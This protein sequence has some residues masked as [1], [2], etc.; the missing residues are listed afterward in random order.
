MS[1]KVIRIVNI[2]VLLS[3]CVILLS[4][5]SKVNR[6][7]DKSLGSNDTGKL[8]IVTTIFPYYDFVRQIAGDKVELRLVVPAGMDTHSFEPTAEDMIAISEADIFIYN[9]G[10]MESWVE[11]VLS[12]TDTGNQR[13]E[14]MIEQVDTLEEEFVEGMSG[15]EGN[16]G[17]SHN[18]H[19]HTEHE[20]SADGEAEIDEHIWTSPENAKILVS[21][22]L[23]ILIG[24]D[25][26]N[27][28]FYSKNADIYIKK[29][30]ELDNKIS[31]IV[32]KGKRK[33]LVFAD[34]FP[35]RYF[36]EEYGIGY[37]AAFAG[38]SADIEPSADTIAYLTDK[39][40]NEKIPVVLKIELTSSRV[41]NV[42][43]DMTGAEVELFYTC[44]NVTRKQFEHGISYVELM[45]HNIRVLKKALY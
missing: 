33:N 11:R 9:G 41:A 16:E 12:A 8:K 7:Q 14:A 23:N 34:R 32:S 35:L 5:C 3:L 37:S 20:D 19:G 31:E 38:C 39:V 36:T 4:G 17:H 13:I 44:H 21:Y 29:L 6:R 30:D 45:E 10:P 28:D 40:K 42:I 1:L 18:A 25:S 24:E 26:V 43:A 22:I 15:G 2:L 27:S